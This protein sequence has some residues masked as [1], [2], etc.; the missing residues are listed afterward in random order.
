MQV[1][2]V[3]QGDRQLGS[4]SAAKGWREEHGAALHPLHRYTQV[5]Q[6]VP[7]DSPLH[8]LQSHLMDLK[9]GARGG[10]EPHKFCG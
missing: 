2:A 1:M 8:G 3:A 5:M 10:D 4:S 7:Q 9:T 6:A